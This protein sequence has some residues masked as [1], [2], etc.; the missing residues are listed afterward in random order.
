MVFL[1]SFAL[2]LYGLLLRLVAP[3]VPKARLWTDGRRNLLAHISQQLAADV[4]PRV[5]FHCAS[6]GEFEQGRPLM[7]AFRRQYPQHRIVLTFFS[8]SGYEVRRQWPGADYVFYLPLDTAANARA[9]VAAV[10]PE[11]AVF[12]KYEFWYHHLAEL[13]RQ[14]VPVICVS[15]IFR[16]QQAF[17]KPWGGFFRRILGQFAHIFTQDEASVA[18]LRTAGIPHASAVGDTRFDTVVDT[19]ATAAK[20]LPLVEA[21]VADNASVLVAGSVWPP[22][23]EVLAPAFRRWATEARFI[24]APHEINEPHLQQVEQALP[25]QVVRYSQATPATVAQARVLLIDNIGLLR[26]LYRVG[27]VGY[28]GGAFGKGLHNTLEAAAF[29]LPLLFGPRYEK[30][31]EARDLVASGCAVVVHD[32]TELEQHLATWLAEPARRQQLGT[33]ARTYVHE[34][35][36]A[37][38]RILHAIRAWLPGTTSTGVTSPSATPFP[39]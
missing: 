21:F 20:H 29:G 35:A 3:F 4:A 10:R 17:F 15:A 12:V 37:T 11:L 36:G 19:A 22:D 6:L 16:P 32:P 14:G 33:R 13:K 31:R 26:E 25:G 27:D 7:E 2:R 28:I 9:F 38:Q 1:Y 8:P 5:W 24:V 34:Q 18:L 23:V 30:F 39:S